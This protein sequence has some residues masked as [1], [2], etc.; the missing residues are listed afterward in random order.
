[1][2][3]RFGPERGKENKATSTPDMKIKP[4]TNTWIRKWTRECNVARAEDIIDATN[5]W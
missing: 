4:V 1:M 3:N 2:W 5:S